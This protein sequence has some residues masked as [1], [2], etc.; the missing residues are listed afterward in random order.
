MIMNATFNIQK[1]NPIKA[2]SQESHMT[3]L[4]ARLAEYDF[5]KQS[6]FYGFLNER[7]FLFA[8]WLYKFILPSG[9]KK[10]SQFKA[11]FTYPQKG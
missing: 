1:T 8:K 3:A 4:K 10:Q 7:N 5:E 6:Q 9:S 2:N 11:N